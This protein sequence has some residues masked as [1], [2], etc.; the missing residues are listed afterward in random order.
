MSHAKW[1]I[2]NN[3]VIVSV[4]EELFLSLSNNSIKVISNERN[5]Q[6]IPIII[7]QLETKRCA[8]IPD[9]NNLF[10]SVAQMKRFHTVIQGQ[11]DNL[12]EQE[13]IEFYHKANTIMGIE[14]TVYF[15]A[16]IFHKTIFKNK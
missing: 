11:P 10:K 1:F 2:F 13:D 12:P 7:S 14:E 6:L 4:N 5:N 3:K 16:R 9:I 15:I 8:Q